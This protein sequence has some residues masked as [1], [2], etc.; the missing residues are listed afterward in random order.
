M[1]DAVDKIDAGAMPDIPMLMFAS[2]G[3]QTQA[4]NW[5]Q[6]QHDYAADL[7]NAMVV[8]LGCGH[9]VHHFESERIAEETKAFLG[10]LEK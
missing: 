6:L 8:E 1:P 10:T 5:V 3:R 4:K 7:S 9:Y 2:D